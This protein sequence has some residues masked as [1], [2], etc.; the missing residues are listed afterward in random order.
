MKVFNRLIFGL[1]GVFFCT[2]VIQAKGE[3]IT[4]QIHE[5]NAN[6]HDGYVQSLAPLVTIGEKINALIRVTKAAPY[7]ASL[8]FVEGRIGL[9][10]GKNDCESYMTDKVTVQTLEDLG[11]PL[12]RSNSA[13]NSIQLR[14]HCRYMLTSFIRSAV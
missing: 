3:E 11:Y 12:I 6:S 14:R 1:I 8:V 5:V 10:I 7:T 2:A 9:R 13:F 4:E